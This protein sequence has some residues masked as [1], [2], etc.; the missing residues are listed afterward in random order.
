MRSPSSTLFVAC[1]CLLALLGAGPAQALGFGF[2]TL[3]ANGEIDAAPGATVGWGYQI[4]NTA[5]DR[6]LVI[7]A[8]DA[9][10]F[11]QGTPDASLFDFP[12]LAP[13]TSLDVPYDGASGLFAFRW[14]AAAP[15]GFTNQGHF[16]LAADWYDGNPFAGGS[17]IEAADDATAPYRVSVIPEP[18]SGLLLGL[19]LVAFAVARRG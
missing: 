12:I 4:T 8:L 2:E 13:G 1:L 10:V 5:S 19:G 18:G 15:P 14:S 9:G 3:P 11:S 6:W 17:F 7:Q 16:T